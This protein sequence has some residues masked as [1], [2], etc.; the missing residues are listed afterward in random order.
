MDVSKAATEAIFE[1]ICSSLPR[2]SFSGVF[3]ETV[4]TEQ[5]QIFPE[6]CLFAETDTIFPY[7]AL[8]RSK[9]MVV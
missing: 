2:P 5:I 8:T 7:D 1:K 9:R 4:F 6:V 3:Q